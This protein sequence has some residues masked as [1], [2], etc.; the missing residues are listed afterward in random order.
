MHLYLS[1]WEATKISPCIKASPGSTREIA[2]YK[3]WD[4][5]E[6]RA[7]NQKLQLLLSIPMFI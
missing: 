3:P 6:M 4:Y 7:I 1:N 2:S 5:K